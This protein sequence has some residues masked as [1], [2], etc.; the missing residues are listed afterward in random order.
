MAAISGHAI[1]PK[2]YPGIHQNREKDSWSCNKTEGR[3]KNDN[4][5]RSCE[6]NITRDEKNGLDLH[7]KGTKLSEENK[8]END[9]KL[10][11]CLLL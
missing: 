6:S 8:V 10:R 5:K 11:P 7:K 9:T 2:N 4:T 1:S 3:I